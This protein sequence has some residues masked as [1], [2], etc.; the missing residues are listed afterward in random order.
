M[1]LG[2]GRKKNLYQKSRF[3]STVFAVTILKNKN[4]VELFLAKNRLRQQKYGESPKV[5]IMSLTTI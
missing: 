3:S 2:A 5:E 1:E 4:L